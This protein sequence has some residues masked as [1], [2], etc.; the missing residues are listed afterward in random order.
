ML[1]ETCGPLAKDAGCTLDFTTFD[2]LVVAAAKKAGATVLIRVFQT[3]GGNLDTNVDAAN[4]PTFL[5]I[6]RL[7]D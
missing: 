5:Q 2:G 3:S 4:A 7:H 1:E 6:D